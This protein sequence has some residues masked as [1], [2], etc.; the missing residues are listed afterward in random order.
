MERCAGGCGVAS[1]KQDSSEQS[2]PSQQR[3]S[4]DNDRDLSPAHPTHDDTSAPDPADAAEPDSAQ[5]EPD[6]EPEDLQLSQADLDALLQELETDDAPSAADLT[7]DT[8]LAPSLDTPLV[9]TP[10]AEAPLVSGQSGAGDE[11]ISNES[12]DAFPKD[13][14][15]SDEPLVE[16]F[17]AAAPTEMDADAAAALERHLEDILP[18]ETPEP[19]DP[20]DAE[21]GGENIAAAVH[22]S[23]PGDPSQ[24][25]ISLPQ[26][27]LDQLVDAAQ[28]QRGE[29][30]EAQAKHEPWLENEEEELLSELRPAPVDNS[31]PPEDAAPQTDLP[32]EPALPTMEGQSETAAAP[33][34]KT[35]EPAQKPKRI[36]KPF[37]LS[38]RA[39]R[40]LF[41]LTASLAAGIM[42]AAAVYVYGTVFPTRGANMQA[43]NRITAPPSGSPGPA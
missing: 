26:D 19:L 8:P 18:D 34:A 6:A 35:P 22:E 39:R 20:T 15:F 12:N 14:A 28:N 41:K 38:S 42:A 4:G 21:V 32:G 10:S 23:A 16:D 37:R 36:R 5:P 7:D 25:E 3:D 17:A 27:M 30:D 33:V 9:D 29:G 31:P 43:L 2:Q 24:G 11:V 40:D 1:E 13:D